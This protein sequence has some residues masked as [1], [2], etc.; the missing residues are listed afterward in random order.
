M[1]A[2][3]PN[4]Q[5]FAPLVPLCPRGLPHP[6]LKWVGGKSQ[7]LD[8][9]RA[10]VNATGGFGAYHEPFVGGGALFFDLARRGR[11]GGTVHLSDGNPNLIDVWSGVQ[12]HVD[13]LVDTLRRHAAKHD[14]AYYYAMR[15]SV[16]ADPVERAARII[17][18]NKTC[19]N[20]LY[21]ENAKGQFN[22]PFGKYANPTIC[23]EANLRAASRALARASLEV[24]SFE[25]VLDRA[26]AGDLVYFDP[27][28][29][30]LTP[31]SSFTSYARMGFGDADQRRLG[32]VFATLDRRGVM[33]I[34][35]NSWTPRVREIYGAFNLRHVLARRAVNSRADRRGAVSEALVSNF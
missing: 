28:Y 3:T 23:D 35:S 26:R 24:R 2:H 29:V 17:Y 25:A 34:L 22:V 6:F 27:P 30:P 7:L 32:E 12:S 31:T 13:R 21:R 4:L 19:F 15:S 10:L 11:L 8:E 14:E 1:L 5:P 9:L 16:P 18:L 20:G 33:V